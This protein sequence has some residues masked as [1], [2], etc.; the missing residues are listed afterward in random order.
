MKSYSL[1]ELARHHANT[2]SIACRY[3]VESDYQQLAN[4]NAEL[5]AKIDRMQTFIKLSARKWEGVAE[6]EP[7][8]WT[9]LRVANETPQQCLRDRDAEVGRAGF[10]AGAKY[11]YISRE[12]GYLPDVL[13]LV[14]WDYAERLKAGEV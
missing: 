8:F 7:T 6:V 11:V 9:L 10:V 4:Q 2:A 13:K 5:V 3:V 14:S 12:I 1:E